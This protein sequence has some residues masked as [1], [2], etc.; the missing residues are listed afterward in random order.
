MEDD[1][2]IEGDSMVLQQLVWNKEN[3]KERKELYYHADVLLQNVSGGLHIPAQTVVSFDTYFNLFIA[4]IWKKYTRI[5][6]VQISLTV[7]GK[8]LVRLIGAEKCVIGEQNFSGRQEILFCIALAE[9]SYFYLEI[10]TEEETILESGWIEAIHTPEEIK[11]ALVTCTYNRKEALKKNLQILQ[12]NN[13]AQAT[14]LERIYV[15]DNAKSLT[16]EEVE[17]ERTVLI[18]NK[19]TGGAGGFTRGL[20]EALK[21][22]DITHII[23]MDDDVQIEFEA[24]RRTKALLSFLKKEY[25]EHFLGG[26]MLRMDKP[27]MLHAA[28]E[29]WADGHIFNPYKNT[30]IRTCEAVLAVSEGISTKQAYAAWWY[31]CVPRSHVEQ[32]G[33]PMPFFLHCD[34]VEYGLRSK[35]APIYLNGIGVWHEEF[36]DKRSSVTEYYDVRNRYITNAIYKEK[37]QVC[38]ALLTL[39]ERFC[40]T[41]CRYRY[42]DFL[43]SVQ[44]V[45]DFLKGADWLYETDAERLH[46]SLGMQGY[47]PQKVKQKPRHMTYAKKST[48]KDVLWYLLP[49]KGSDVIRMGAP[50]SAYAKKRQILLVEPKTQ[51]GF[52]VKKSWMETF[53]CMYLLIKTSISL[54]YNYKKVAMQW[55]KKEFPK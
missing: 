37:G 25:K 20:R 49:A 12:Q 2:G 31:C 7:Q 51:K 17:D 16:A 39:C 8:G 13:T 15:I 21:Q 18:P 27:Y 33:Y 32:K 24:L 28:G 44:G 40:A 34:D 6:Q 43:L 9:N 3:R 30:D 26:A 29:D 5:E 10:Q 38:D 42:Q 23:L 4:K 46:K 54:I 22:K 19:N 41:V 35:K 50:I 1:A 36:D 45:E 48:W 47:H 55:Q 14:V 53:K 52:V 11:L